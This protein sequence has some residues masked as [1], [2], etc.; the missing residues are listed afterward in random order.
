MTRT[1]KDDLRAGVNQSNQRPSQVME[2]VQ[3]T[4]TPQTSEP[5][6]VGL[7]PVKLV[8]FE[9]DYKGGAFSTSVKCELPII[10]KRKSNQKAHHVLLSSYA[11]AQA[12][13]Y[14]FDRVIDT[15]FCRGLDTVRRLHG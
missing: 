14:C 7:R 3:T 8:K 4:T 9:M 2:A 11:P 1:S 15:V 10:K 5:P 12:T 13:L 6:I